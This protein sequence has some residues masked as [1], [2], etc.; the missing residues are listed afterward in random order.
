[1]LAPNELESAA[2]GELLQVAGRVADTSPGALILAGALG[3]LQVLLA[4]NASATDHSG[5]ESSPAVHPPWEPGWLLVVEGRR[6]GRRLVEARVVHAFEA[7]NPTAAGEHARLVWQ[8]SGPWL[9]AR[10]RALRA[11]R[12]YFDA[13]GFVEVETPVRVAAPNL[14]AN[15]EVVHTEQGWLITSPE[16]AMKRLLVGGLHRCYQLARCTRNGELG[17]WHEPEFTMLEWYRAFCG[18][19]ATITDTESLIVAVAV[20]VNGEP[21]LRRAGQLLRLC[22]P[23]ERMTVREAFR[24]HAGVEDAAALAAEDEARYFELLVGQVEPALMARSEPV[25]LWD[26]P[27]TQGALARPRPEDPVVV[28][29]FEIYAL[30][31]EL[32]NGYGELTDP[33]ANRSRLTAEAKCRHQ[34]TG[35][36]LPLDHALLRALEEGL[37]PSSGVAMGF[38]RLVALA[39]GA[40]GVAAVSALPWSRRA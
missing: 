2:P 34:A 21:V 1:V 7:P 32:C 22:P 31:V 28:E 13:E 6:E 17:L 8:G 36:L 15:V 18:L 33:Q 9:A 3:S 20:A 38:D 24:L 19:E 25:L 14:D 27:I 4:S 35:E 37:P 23:F 30:G 29:R 16:Y 39:A 5:K 11:V 12:S 26:Y 10:A 40:P